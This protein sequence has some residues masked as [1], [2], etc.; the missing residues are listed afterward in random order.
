MAHVVSSDSAHAP[1]LTGAAPRDALQRSRPIEPGNA[2]SA[3]PAL[4]S[5]PHARAVLEP[6]LGPAGRPSHAYLFHGPPGSGRRTAARAVAASLLAQGAPEP[7]S[8][9]A[10]VARGTHPDLTW[11]TPSGAAEMLVADID[12]PVVAAAARAPFEAARR[13]FV[14]DRAH[15]MNDQAANRMLKTLEEPPPFVHLILVA[16]SVGE[17]MATIASRCQLVRFAPLPATRIEERL[18]AGLGDGRDDGPGPGADDGEAA[19]LGACARLAL[20]DAHLARAL[21]GDEGRALRGAAEAYVRATLHGRTEERPWRALL[22]AAARAG[23]HAREQLDAHLAEEQELLPRRER[24]RHRREGEEAAR[25][26]ERRERTRA[27]DLGLRVAE[28]WLRDLL[29][30]AEGAPELVHALDR[31]QE[32]DRDAAGADR[33]RLRE[34]VELVADTR[35]R[36]TVNVSEELAL[37]ALAYRLEALLGARA[38]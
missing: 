27:L 31:S 17:V 32:L 25:R 22:D 24:A 36:L 29:C 8:V 4:E 33:Q 2:R 13:V 9:R 16:D 18:R 15:T 35:L 7:E 3:L 1:A 6:A 10:R 14:I 37:E 28:L 34:G 5:Q 38:S 19:R 12:E 20:G 26:T 11:V 30:L 21:A 23:A